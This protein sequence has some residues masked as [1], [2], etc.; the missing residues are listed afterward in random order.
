MKLD[1]N[2]CLTIHDFIGTEKTV[3]I[4]FHD[5]VRSPYH[6]CAFSVDLSHVQ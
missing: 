6:H 3:G 2:A 4:S 1:L 5:E